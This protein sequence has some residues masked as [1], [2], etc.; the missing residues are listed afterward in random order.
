MFMSCVVPS[1]SASD[2]ASDAPLADGEQRRNDGAR[3]AAAVDDRS[4]NWIRSSVD[5]WSSIDR[6]AVDG[7]HFNSRAN[8]VVLHRAHDRGARRGQQAGECRANDASTAAAASDRR[9]DG[10]APSGA[11]AV[12]RS[13]RR[14]E[15]RGLQSGDSR[16]LARDRRRRCGRRRRERASD[17]VVNGQCHADGGRAAAS[18]ISSVV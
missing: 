2:R 1:D 16:R 4:R 9:R 10:R 12:R 13:I 3:H 8:P 11:G 6:P 14:R 5:H 18:A 17:L 7:P 15:H